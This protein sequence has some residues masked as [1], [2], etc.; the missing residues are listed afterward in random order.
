MPNGTDEI[1]PDPSLLTRFTEVL[2]A[3]K[4][5]TWSI[6]VATVD[7]DG[8]GTAMLMK[9]LI[10]H[11]GGKADIYYGG[12]FSHPQNET[13]WNLFELEK[14]L[15]PLAEL[16]DTGPLALADSCKIVD[17]RFHKELEADRFRIVVDHHRDKPL[18]EEGRCVY[19]ASCGA[20]ATLAYLLIEGLNRKY[21]KGK[22]RAESFSPLA[23][24]EDAATLGAIG[25]MSD[26]DCLTAPSVREADHYAYAAL[27]ASGS[28]ERV[29]LSFN[30][31]LPPRFYE[32]Q[33]QC[34]KAA[35]VVGS[36]LITR[37]DGLIAFSEGDFLGIIAD[38]LRKREGIKTVVVWGMTEAA[39]RGSIRTKSRELNLTNFIADIFGPGTG[40]GKH[41]S[42][43]ARVALPEQ[44]LPTP[45]T[46]T[47]LIAFFDA[48]FREKL[49]KRVGRKAAL[50]NETD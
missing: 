43:G 2:E 15:R 24:S 46:A 31:D 39:L 47:H 42:G 34:L 10:L 1:R 20:A 28:Q 9:E 49:E 14:H 37:P 12:A 13:I 8:L 18:D 19:I 45:E 35:T 16:P 25:I 4:E 5:E 27:M 21:S 41:G 29:S 44:F 36:Y 30:Y 17:S 38:E 50:D 6:I 40:G 48:S 23:I 22:H 33:S 11:F 3:H 32:V 7:P 26:T